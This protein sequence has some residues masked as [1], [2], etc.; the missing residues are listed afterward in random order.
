METMIALAVLA[1]GL[2][3]TAQ[4]MAFSMGMSKD[5]GDDLLAR[6]K[7]TEAIESVFTGRDN[8][9][10]GVNTWMQIRNVIGET[11][12]DNG[13]FRDGFLPLTPAGADGLVNTADDGVVL[14]KIR[15]PGPDGQLGTVDDVDRYLT[16]FQRKIEI[17]AV[18][19]NPNLRRIRV[20]IQYRGEGR[21]R[22][23]VIDTFI[24]AFA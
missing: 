17:T 2:L 7:A 16:N 12:T 6:Q 1:T 8:R 13:V 11:G 10:L 14:D 21:T 24:S 23:F 3:A 5:S 9:K 15:Q 20:T 22:E 19:G 18:A 4:V